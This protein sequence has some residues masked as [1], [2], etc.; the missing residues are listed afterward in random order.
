MSDISGSGR[1]GLIGLVFHYPDK[2]HSAL[3][4]A[5]RLLVVVSFAIAFLALIV[6]QVLDVESSFLETIQL[7]I[8]GPIFFWSLV[9]LFLLWVRRSVRERD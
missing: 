5:V 6:Q 8:A 7:R 9:V 4:R 3:V 2:H 1:T